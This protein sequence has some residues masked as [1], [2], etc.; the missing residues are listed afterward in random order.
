MLYYHCKLCMHHLLHPWVAN[1][2]WGWE[3]VARPRGHRLWMRR[4]CS[5]N[6]DND[7]ALLHFRGWSKCTSCASEAIDRCRN[8][9]WDTTVA[10]SIA[11]IRVL[12]AVAAV[13]TSK[14]PHELKSTAQQKKKKNFQ[15]PSLSHSLQN[16]QYTLP[17]TRYGHLCVTLCTVILPIRNLPPLTA[18]RSADCMV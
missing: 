9:E 11:L 2:R 6:W 1:V 14:T 15:A 13:P 5:D 12:S 10:A 7:G 8:W 3:S 17:S 18:C 4:C 16:L